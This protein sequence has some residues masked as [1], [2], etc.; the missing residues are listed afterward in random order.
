MTARNEFY[1]GA[2]SELMTLAGPVV[3]GDMWARYPNFTED[4]FRCTHTGKVAMRVAFMDKL[5]ALR[6]EF[7]R[8]II[9]TSGYRDPTHIVEA[10]KE[11]PGAHT[12]GIAA[13][14]RASGADA[15]ELLCW[16]CDLGFPRIGVAQN[17]M[18][19]FLHL[20]IGTQAVGLPSPRVWTY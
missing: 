2:H 10:T 20:D 15:Y 8:P 9:V 16:A 11:K 1:Y 7:G 6:H 18:R 4:E 17:G 3:Q 13:D 19:R 14:I 12:M 5:Q